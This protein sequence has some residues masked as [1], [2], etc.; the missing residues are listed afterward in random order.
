MFMLRSA[1]HHNGDNPA[2]IQ[3]GDSCADLWATA[4]DTGPANQGDAIILEALGGYE[5][6]G[7]FSAPELAVKV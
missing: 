1:D 3:V 2:I 5:L 6:D 4:T 7:F